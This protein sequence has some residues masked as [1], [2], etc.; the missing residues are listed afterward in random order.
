MG[1]STLPCRRR[2][3]NRQ[4]PAL[5]PRRSVA[6]LAERAAGSHDHAPGVSAER[7]R[8]GDHRIGGG[9]RSATPEPPTTSRPMSRHGDHR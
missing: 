8:C 3:V 1:A 9:G 7:P 5:R 2:R 4:S 6:V